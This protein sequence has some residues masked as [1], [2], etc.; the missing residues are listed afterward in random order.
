MLVYV[1]NRSFPRTAKRV[2]NFSHALERNLKKIDFKS[3]KNELELVFYFCVTRKQ[4]SRV[5][6]MN[7]LGQLKL[8]LNNS[9]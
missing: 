6:D 2:T 1:K 4:I 9:R 8:T 7:N 3:R 5:R